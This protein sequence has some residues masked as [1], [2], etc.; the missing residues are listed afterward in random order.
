MTREAFSKALRPRGSS[1]GR[2]STAFDPD[3]RSGIVEAPDS[4]FSALTAFVR[5][6]T[7][8]IKLVFRSCKER[9][10]DLVDVLNGL[11]F[12][13]RSRCQEFGSAM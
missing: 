13:D 11:V 5:I 6:C 10:S 1:D 2:R 4:P 8:E 12:A 9:N 3:G 7:D